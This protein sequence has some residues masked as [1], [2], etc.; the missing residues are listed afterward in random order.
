MA[1]TTALW[2]LAATAVLLFNTLPAAAGPT[3]CPGGGAID[4]W[5]LAASNICF[6]AGGEDFGKNHFAKF[7]LNRPAVAIKLA[8]RKGG[9]NCNAADRQQNSKWGCDAFATAAL[10]TFIAK[11]T[12]GGTPVT[13]GN[14]PT[15]ADIVAPPFTRRAKNNMAWYAPY[16]SNWADSDE[17][18]F[19]DGSVWQN[20]N[21]A[22]GTV[23][24]QEP[25]APGAYGVWY[26]EDLL[27]TS[28][29]DN[30]GQTCVDVYALAASGLQLGCLSASIMQTI[31]AR[32]I[33]GEIDPVTLAAQDSSA[34][35]TCT[36]AV[37]QW[38]VPADGSYN[39]WMS[40]G[41]GGFG[42]NKHDGYNGGAAGFTW[43]TLKLAKGAILFIHVGCAGASA[44]V[45][46]SHAN[47]AAKFCG[48]VTVK[49]VPVGSSDC[50][51]LDEAYSG[52]G[53]SGVGQ[54]ETCTGGVGGG[55]GGGSGILQ[56]ESLL[57]VAGGAGGHAGGWDTTRASEENPFGGLGGGAAGQDGGAGRR[58]DGGGTP[59]T[60]AGGG[61]GG[62]QA[63]P[64]EA[65]NPR[66]AG[67]DHS[68]GDAYVAQE[69][70]ILPGTNNPRGG[71]GFG[72][73]GNGH[74]LCT[75]DEHMG[76]GGGGGGG[77]FGGG[78][79]S[80]LCDLGTGGGG[81]SGYVNTRAA[82]LIGGGTQ[83]GRGV[84]ETIPGY[85]LISRAATADCSDPF[86]PP[87][88]SASSGLSNLAVVVLLVLVVG[89]AVVLIK[90]GYAKTPAAGVGDEALVIGK[91]E[92]GMAYAGDITLDPGST[93]VDA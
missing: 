85:V 67:K 29:G 41:G 64:G 26:G 2:L 55:G 52:E 51:L 8:Y 63:A 65:L 40:G 49:C 84:S 57:L 15:E 7:K 45:C 88:P 42:S 17:L 11:D 93:P 54:T 68:G 16:D 91:E 37:Q 81:G 92:P 10:S 18:T 32:A 83:A 75:G 82:A 20:G 66:S 19:T 80:S 5:E 73:G 24:S 69:T 77:Y 48:G 70:Y 76:G 13:E 59:T 47:E 72:P 3:S 6:G 79:G 1:A 38:T 23:H 90:K 60:C 33:E 44:P 58:Q 34:H 22:E 9:V 39:V 50:T 62:T 28:T 74:D 21:L 31:E 86:A 53:G 30:A 78:G 14:K 27:T 4:G 56:G 43:A 87:P 25:F 61:K 89:F 46:V 71:W 12:T 36:G 35:F